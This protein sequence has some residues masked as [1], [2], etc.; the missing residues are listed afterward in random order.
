M[1]RSY[2]VMALLFL[3]S[4]L[5][6]AFAGCDREVEEIPRLEISAAILD[7]GW[8]GEEGS[9][10]VQN[11][12]EGTLSWEIEVDIDWLEVT[13]LSG[14]D[15]EEIVVRIDREKMEVGTHS[16]GIDI[17]SEVGEKS[18]LIKAEVKD[19]QD[20]KPGAVERFRVEGIT[21]PKGVADASSLYAEIARDRGSEVRSLGVPM[22]LDPY[23]M[24]AGYRGGFTLSWL[25]ISSPVGLEGIRI[26][27]WD[28]ERGRY[29]K[30]EEVAIEEIETQE[31]EGEIYQLYHRFDAEFPVYLGERLRVVGYNEYGYGEISESD[32]GFILPP[33]EKIT[34][35][36]GSS[37]EIK[38]PKFMWEKVEGV[39]YYRPAVSGP[40]IWETIVDGNEAR[41]EEDLP[42]GNYE[43]FT[44]GYGEAMDYSVSEVWTF[45]VK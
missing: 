41:V 30:A 27:R 18:L 43:W 33:V 9:F 34:P 8:E 20:L 12:G 24:P 40:V 21:A 3:L 17:Q 23:P 7:L 39:D 36:D 5:F 4:L 15:D 16:A 32:T 25:E 1:N 13:P 11:S 14:T 38:K 28:E 2:K 22:D 19:P 29:V 26:D 45:D 37:L 6:T 44:V 10:K 42:A 31:I 35:A